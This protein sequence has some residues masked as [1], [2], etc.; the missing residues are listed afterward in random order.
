MNNQSPPGVFPGITPQ[1]MLAVLS[2]NH[3][4]THRVH[5]AINDMK[6]GQD[7][8]H[9]LDK[10]IEAE[11]SARQL[12]IE[13]A[14]EPWC[15]RHGLTLAQGLSVAFDDHSFNPANPDKDLVTMKDLF[16]WGGQ[17]ND[18]AQ[19]MLTQMRPTAVAQTPEVAERQSER[20]G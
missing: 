16:A 6:D 15:D 1:Q 5:K 11:T 17:Q 20:C 3:I 7:P 8:Q 18:F 4:G 9:C 10:A 12:W 14:L 2:R 13:V 19:F